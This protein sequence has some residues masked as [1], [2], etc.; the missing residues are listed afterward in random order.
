[1]N[2][3]RCSAENYDFA[4]FCRKCGKKLHSHCNCWVKKAPYDCGMEK[5]PGKQ[6][7]QE[8]INPCSEVSDAEWSA[9]VLRSLISYHERMHM[10]S[11]INMKD[12]SDFCERQKNCPAAKNDGYL[13]ALKFALATVE[14]KLQ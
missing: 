13:A 11:L 8:E 2:C 1:M 12:G 4:N 10:G 3:P 14:E 6:L 7:L 5:C 9:F